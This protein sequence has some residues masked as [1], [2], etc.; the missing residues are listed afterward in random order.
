M[1]EDLSKKKLIRYVSV[2]IIRKLSDD[3]SKLI[4]EQV[5]EGV[6]HNLNSKVKVITKRIDELKVLEKETVDS[7]G[8][9][10]EI[11]QIFIETTE[12]KVSIQEV[13][14]RADELSSQKLTVLNINDKLNAQL[15]NQVLPDLKR[16]LKSVK[17][18]SVKIKSF[19][20]EL[21]EWL[22]F[23]DSCEAV[24]HDS[25]ELS[26]A[27]KFTYLRSYLTDAA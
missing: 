12:L 23:L 4:T 10:D 20:R 27:Q 3:I 16:H 8:N 15:E 14:S 5:N 25:S 17:L 2:K 1:A 22:S 24:I 26:D 7:T 13:L 11:T 19:S 21:T 9:T 6:K 18:P